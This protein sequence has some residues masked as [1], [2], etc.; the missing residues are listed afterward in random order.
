MTKPIDLT[1][2]LGIPPLPSSSPDTISALLWAREV[3]QK[4]LTT[5]YGV[6][7]PKGIE[8]LRSV[9]IGG[10]DQW[11]HIR[12][13]NRDNPVLLY[14]HGGPGGAMIGTMDATMRPWEDFFTIVHWDQRQTGKSY[15][16]ADDKG[17][18]LHIDQFIADTEEV[19]QHLRD[20]LNQK[21]IFLVG[22]S[23]G[24][25]LGIYIAKRHPNWLHAY[26]GFGQV[27]SWMDTQEV[28]DGR[29]LMH[30]EVQQEHELVSKLKSFPL[31][32]DSKIPNREKSHVESSLYVIP[33]LNRLAGEALMHHLSAEELSRIWAFEKL[34]SPHLTLTDLSNNVLGDEY[35]FCRPPYTLTK[36]LIDVDL[37]AQV[38]SSF[39]VPIFFFSGTHDFQTPT[40]LSDQWFN[41]ITAPHK[42]LVHFNE[43]S[44][45]IVNEEPGKVLVEL[46]TKVLPCAQQ[47]NE[48][49]AKN[50]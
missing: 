9:K 7:D 18:P 19:I 36:E 5:T 33:Q 32:S 4:H 45:I 22:H 49:S 14:L 29:L 38:G 48:G 41:D 13:R 15:Y 6:T 8:E 25:I 34:I 47:A 24:T 11:I 35:A 26:I 1:A 16:P 23:W 10:I 44:H 50:C 21:K 27:V 43:S 20:H 31:L 30:A 46:V 3:L 12:G 37:P 28:R 17:S 40:S 39:D 42:E 2:T